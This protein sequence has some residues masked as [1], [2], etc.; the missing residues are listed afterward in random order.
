[1]APDDFEVLRGVGGMKARPSELP[2]GGHLLGISEGL[3]ASTD[4]GIWTWVIQ[5]ENPPEGPD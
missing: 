4:P 3:S 5:L 1:V 2:S